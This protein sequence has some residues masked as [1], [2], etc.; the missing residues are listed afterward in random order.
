M[1]TTTTKNFSGRSIN[2]WIGGQEEGHCHGHVTSWSVSSGWPRRIYKWATDVLTSQS[3]IT[4]TT[5]SGLGKPKARDSGKTIGRG[6]SNHMVFILLRVRHP[7][8]LLKVTQRMVWQCQK[9]NKFTFSHSPQDNSHIPDQSGHKITGA[10]AVNVSWL[11]VTGSPALWPVLVLLVKGT[12][13]P[14]EESSQLLT[15]L[16]WLLSLVLVPEMFLKPEM[17]PHVPQTQQWLWTWVNRTYLRPWGKDRSQGLVRW[18][19]G[20]MEKKQATYDS[21]FPFQ[22]PHLIGDRQDK[23]VI[24]NF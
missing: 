18:G 13:W 7:H 11:D 22:G 16:I 21:S 14:W 6:L 9:R 12:V 8:P 24:I 10:T 19:V 4:R 15:N 2:V 17:V 5:L 20:I 23:D 3:E 1:G